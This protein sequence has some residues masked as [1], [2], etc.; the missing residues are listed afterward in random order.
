MVHQCVFDYFRENFL[1]LEVYYKHFNVETIKT[2]PTYEVL[3]NAGL[4]E[5]IVMYACM[6][7]VSFRPYKMSLTFV[8]EV[9]TYIAFDSF[10]GC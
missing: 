7:I 5:L 10:G 3:N 2:E 4:M 8:F 9:Y 1:K 6:G